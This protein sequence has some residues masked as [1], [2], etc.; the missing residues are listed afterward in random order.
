MCK[1]GHDLGIGRIYCQVSGFNRIIFSGKECYGF[2][3]PPDL[4][5]SNAFFFA[6]S[7]KVYG[8][9]CLIASGI[10]VVP[11]AFGNANSLYALVCGS[12]DLVN[13]AANIS[14]ISSRIDRASEADVRGDGKVI[15]DCNGK[16]A[17]LSSG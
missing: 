5:D 1:G 13:K 16:G 17:D 14:D 9:I 11:G 7:K 12:F 6:K 2:S 8:R 15:E 10:M 4:F 3:K